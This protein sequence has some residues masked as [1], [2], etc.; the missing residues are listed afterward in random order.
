MHEITRWLMIQSTSWALARAKAQRIRDPA[1]DQERQHDNPDQ[2]Y[3]AA[4]KG[5]AVPVHRSPHRSRASSS[6]LRCL[7]F[8]AGPL[9]GAVELF[10]D[11]PL[12]RLLL[13]LSE[14]RAAPRYA[15]GRGLRWRGRSLAAFRP[16]RLRS[17][18]MRW[19]NSLTIW[20][21]PLGRAL[22]HLVVV[23]DEI[24]RG[25]PPIMS[26]AGAGMGR[27]VSRSLACFPV[28]F[29]A[30]PAFSPCPLR[31]SPGWRGSFRAPGSAGRHRVRIPG[32]ATRSALWFRA[33]GAGRRGPAPRAGI[34][35]FG[36]HRI[37]LLSD[38]RFRGWRP[39]ARPTGRRDG[40]RCRRPAWRGR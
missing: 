39:V 10:L 5:L 7:E 29:R 37:D 2:G 33:P 3:G 14:V 32:A 34:A 27:G 23:L 20:S 6:R 22:A 30:R 28:A 24:A 4:G 19:S 21:R 12:E 36:S 17:A 35:G 16:A 26:K 25:G 15:P 38:R 31:R 9:V 13:A 8:P 18:A 1:G 40:S 11:Q